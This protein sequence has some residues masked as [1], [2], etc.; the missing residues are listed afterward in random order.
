L[1][2][3]KEF[4]DNK[5]HGNLIS[6][7]SKWGEY[8]P[9]WHPWEDYRQSYAA[10][11]ELGGG[12]TLTLSHDIDIVNWIT[13][14]KITRTKSIKNY[15][16]KLEIDV[17]SGCDILYEY[18]NGVTGHSHLNYYSKSHE[19][20]IEF[21]FD[22][23]NIRFDY[24]QSTLKISKPG[25]KEKLIQVKKFERNDLFI[26]ELVEFFQKTTKFAL[27]E[28]IKAVEESEIIMNICKKENW[29][30]G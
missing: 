25:R 16:S 11:R 29:K 21:V 30:N 23:A 26:D 24:I 8:L 2:K 3:V 27:R 4:V 17:E 6:F 7:S 10:R 15:R 9:G 1:K 14:S 5:T 18:S 12:V 13:G 20:Y 22:E 28:S 19:R